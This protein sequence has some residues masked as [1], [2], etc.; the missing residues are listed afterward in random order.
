MSPNQLQAY[1]FAVVALTLAMTFLVAFAPSAYAQDYPNRPVRLIVA[2]TAG[3]TAG[4]T[5]MP[6]DC[7]LKRIL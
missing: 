5:I 6:T 7:C 2:F 1:R 4:R 3:G